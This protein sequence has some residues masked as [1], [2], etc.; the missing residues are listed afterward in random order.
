MVALGCAACPSSLAPSNAAECCL[1]FVSNIQVEGTLYIPQYVNSPFPG[2]TF[3][4]DANGMPIYQASPMMLDDFL[5]LL[6]SLE[7]VVGF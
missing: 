7:P 4:L 3:V 2:A 5:L 1:A 6:A